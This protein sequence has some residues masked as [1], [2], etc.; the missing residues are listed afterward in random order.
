MAEVLCRCG[1]RREKGY[2]Y[3]VDKKGNA[4]RAKMARRGQ[5]TDKR[6]EVVHRCGIQREKG[7]LYFIDTNGNAARARMARR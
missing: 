1:I 7:Y 4:A 3:F 5:K 2:L 6:Q